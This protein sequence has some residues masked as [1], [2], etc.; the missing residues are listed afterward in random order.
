MDAR[1]N[2]RSQG[3]SVGSDQGQGA[4]FSPSVMGRGRGPR[5]RARGRGDVN[6][7]QAAQVNQEAQNWE[8]GFAEMQARIEEQDNEIQRLRQ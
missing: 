1:G 3:I 4:Q 2:N 5:G 8:V 7:P 6:S